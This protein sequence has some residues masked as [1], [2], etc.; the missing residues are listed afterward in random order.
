MPGAGKSTVGIILA[1]LLSFGFVDTDVLIQIRQKRSLQQIIEESG[2]LNLRK[3]EERE[4]LN[5]DVDNHVIATGG[6]AVYSEKG[7]SHLQS[8]SEIVFLKVN[9][10]D[11]LKRIRNFKTRGI[12]KSADQ[13]FLDLYNERQVLYDRY[14]E[15]TIDC[16]ALDQEEVAG[17]IASYYLLRL[18]CSE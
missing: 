16:S 13:S 9:Y 15:M 4:I 17:K 7:M 18:G 1:K 10:E 14:A 11:I 6:S 2:H 12:A 5:I 3:I 8:I